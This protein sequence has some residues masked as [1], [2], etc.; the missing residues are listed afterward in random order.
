MWKAEEITIP[1]DGIKKKFARNP[2]TNDVY[3]L[4]SYND[5]SEFGGEPVLIGRLI[6]KP[7]G[8]F[9]FVKV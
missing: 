1:I 5:A 2:E 9:K 8:K 4:Q 7:D 3:D 6:K